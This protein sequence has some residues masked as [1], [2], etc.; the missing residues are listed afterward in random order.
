MNTPKNFL[1]HGHKYF[2]KDKTGMRCYRHVWKQ[3]VSAQI[4]PG[5][6]FKESN[7]VSAFT[8]AELLTN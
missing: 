6:S 8:M 2:K 1:V 3:F 4:R 7:C 5:L